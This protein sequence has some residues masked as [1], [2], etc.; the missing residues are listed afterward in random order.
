MAAYTRCFTIGSRFVISGRLLAFRLRNEAESGSLALRLACSPDK[1]PPDGLLHP[2]LASATCRTGNLHGE[3]LSVHK[4]KPG[5]SWRTGGAE[6]KYLNDLRGI[7]ARQAS[8]SGFGCGLTAIFLRSP[9]VPPKLRVSAVN[10][11]SRV[12]TTSCYIRDKGPFCAVALISK[13]LSTI[14]NAVQETR[15]PG[16]S[17]VT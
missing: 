7:A 4:I 12:Y 6:R 8:S 13:P 17:I 16:L 9:R 2:T 11:S 1:F 3:L 15:H 14:V 10:P 5:L